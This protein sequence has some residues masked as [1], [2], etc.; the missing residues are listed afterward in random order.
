MELGLSTLKTSQNKKLQKA[1]DTI[2]KLSAD[3]TRALEK[4]A[5]KLAEIDRLRFFESE[6]YK[7]TAEMVKDY[8]GYS[9]Q[10]TSVMI[11]VGNRF[12]LQDGTPNLTVEG[13]QFS[14]YQLQEMLPLYPDELDAH[15]GTDITPGMSAK[16]IRKMV[17]KIQG[18]GE[19]EKVE[20][21]DTQETEAQE[22]SPK[23]GYVGLETLFNCMCSLEQLVDEHPLEFDWIQE[24]GH[25]MATTGK[26]L[27]KKYKRDHNIV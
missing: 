11:R 21:K 24:L 19:P 23:Q 10:T 18:K 2:V 20:K 25:V 9:K 22:E 5:V 13:Q 7:N 8:L 1:L 14:L 17:K 16:E 26:E 15:V 4:I 6:G 3:S 12:F 27:I